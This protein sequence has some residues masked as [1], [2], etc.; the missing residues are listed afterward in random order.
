MLSVLAGQ[1]L[2]VAAFWIAL[3]RALPAAI[4]WLVAGL[5]A[6]AFGVRFFVD[7]GSDGD[8]GD[9]V[10]VGLAAAGA[11]ASAGWGGRF[12]GLL[13]LLFLVAGVYAVVGRS[14]VSRWRADGLC[15]GAAV[16]CAACAV[17][18]AGAAGSLPLLLLSFALA[19]VGRKF[20]PE[21]SPPTMQTRA[22]TVSAPPVLLA[23]GVGAV[24]AALLTGYLPAVRSPAYAVADLGA[25]FFLGALALSPVWRRVRGTP[26]AVVSASLAVLLVGLVAGFSFFSYPDLVA[27]GPAVDQTPTHMLTAGRLFPF[28]GQAFLLGGAAGL[29]LQRT[30]R[31]G[32]AWAALGAGALA[33]VALQHPWGSAPQ[34]VAALLSLATAGIVAYDARRST[35]KASGALVAVA[36]IVS[37]AALAWT[38]AG[39]PSA[40][41]P[42]LRL[43]FGR[44]LGRRDDRGRVVPAGRA[45]EARQTA[46]GSVTKLEWGRA[47]AVF[48]AG[49][50]VWLER[51]HGP[52][53]AASV[54]LAAALA[55]A[56]GPAGESVG[57]VGPALEQTR[58][59]VEALAGAP[60]ADLSRQAGRA[61]EAEYGSLLWGPGPWSAP[62]L[63]PLPTVEELRAVK[64]KSRG[65]LALWVPADAMELGV[66]RKVL[67]TVSHAFDG[68]AVF[69]ERRGVVVL[70]TD[71]PWRL[72][73]SRLKSLF[74][75]S[76][77]GRLLA[78]AG[79]WHP[80]DLL[81]GYIGDAEDLGALS[82]GVNPSLVGRPERP[83]RVARDLTADP[84]MDSLLALEQHRLRGPG[85]ALRRVDFED[86]VQRRLALRGFE[87]I[88]ST[89]TDRLL[90]RLSDTGVPGRRAVVRVLNGPLGRLDL[91]AAG[92]EERRVRLS[93]ALSR[94]GLHQAA[95][96]ALEGAVQSGNGTYAVHYRLGIILQRMGRRM[97]ALQNFRKALEY[98]PES[99][100][101]RRRVV[102]LMLAMGRPQEAADMLETVVERD[103]ESVSSLLMLG[104]V[105]ARTGEYEKAADAARRALRLEPDNSD[106]QELLTLTEQ[107][108]QAP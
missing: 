31:G 41:Y 53:S 42:G 15:L 44:V 13:L 55:V 10:W 91:F 3:R 94:V 16:G 92:E 23:G 96:R 59:T 12:S 8:R 28:W 63:P 81:V 72:R 24:A 82:E 27:S 60:V 68:F 14:P 50:L 90:E 48:R 99:T 76:R 84:H 1:V 20:L 11:V 65:A 100:D 52:E 98:D 40:G 34:G 83:P 56:A 49:N 67:A 51:P 22:W 89:R 36:A 71:G 7:G 38:L 101:A 17:G 103:P 73:Y 107:A 45:V 33:A 77:G 78:R 69:G 19:L 37:A 6:A 93:V 75:S 25:G 62:D 39:D 86:A 35:R 57:L 58:E 79:Y 47:S 26:A 66:L 54:R 105:R 95:V 87:D 2:G 80:A 102:Q 29:L 104:Q 61:D 5:L 108:A 64:P 106:A 9:A 85:R 32:S 70:A 74:A 4:A 30:G 97:P 46:H 21:P 43:S 18:A 88:Y